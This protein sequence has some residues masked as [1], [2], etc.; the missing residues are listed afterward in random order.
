[1]ICAKE[2]ENINLKYATKKRVKQESDRPK[3]TPT[4]S[5]PLKKGSSKKVIGQNIRRLRDE[6]RSQSQALAIALSQSRKGRKKRR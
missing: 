4:Q 5:M 3:H 6:G 1:M 2:K